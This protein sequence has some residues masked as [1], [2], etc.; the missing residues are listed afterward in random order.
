MHYKIE[1]SYFGKQGISSREGMK[2]VN[3]I[4]DIFYAVYLEFFLN[5]KCLKRGIFHFQ[6]YIFSMIFFCEIF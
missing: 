4:I 6:F 1:I 5:N 3:R 2:C